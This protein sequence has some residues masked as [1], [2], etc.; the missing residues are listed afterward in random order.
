M[1]HF[2]SILAVLEERQARRRGLVPSIV[3]AHVGAAAQ[4]SV[5]VDAQVLEEAQALPPEVQ[6][7]IAERQAARKARDFAKADAIRNELGARGIVIEDTPQ[8]IRWRR[9]R[10]E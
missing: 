5:T 1:R 2:D 9:A 6:R 4:A 3:H 8:G 7:L 10:S